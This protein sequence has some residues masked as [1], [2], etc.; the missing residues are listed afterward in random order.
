MSRILNA[1]SSWTKTRIMLRKSPSRRTEV[2][3]RKGTRN[4]RIESLESRQLFAIAPIAHLGDL[5]TLLIPTGTTPV[6]FFADYRESPHND[7]LGYFFVDGP[8]GRITKHQDSD[9]FGT[10]LLS[11]NGKPQYVR[12][13]EPGYSNEALAF[14]NSDVVFSSGEIGNLSN[15]H[16]VLDVYGDFYIAFYLIQG[17]STQAWRDA[18]TNGKPNVWF[19]I[20]DANADGYEHFQSTLR[21]DSFYRRGL[22]QYKVEDSNLALAKRKVAGNDSDLNDFVF[23]VNIVPYAYSD[24]YS[25]FNAG[26]DFNGTPQP[27]KLNQTSGLLWNDYLPSNPYRKPIVTHVSLDGETWNP[28]TDFCRNNIVIHDAS[29]HGT[30]TVFANGSI[31]FQPN[32]TDVWWKTAPVDSEAEPDPIEFQY[33]ISD[34][35]D[36]AEAYVSITHGFYQKGGPVD[37]RHQGKKM[38]L[39]AGGGDSTPFQ[40][41]RK[42]FF[43]EGGNGQDIVLISQGIEQREL[44]N[45][46]FDYYADGKSRSVTSLNITTREQANDPRMSKIVNGADAIWFGGGAQSFYQS[47]WE[48]TALFGAL[49]VAAANNVAIGGTSAGMAI[50]GQAAYVELPWDSV[51]SR[52]ATQ[53]P[54]DPRINIEYQ[55]GQLPFAAL[56]SGS[57]APLNNFITDT[58]FSSR[59][60]M[61]RLVAF[62][63]K[64]NMRGLGVDEETA[65]LIERVGNNWKWSTYGTGSVYIVTPSSTSVRPKYQDNLRLT[66]GPMN[67]YR[68]G[69]GTRNLTDVLSSG[70]S[71]RI[72]VTTGTVYTTENGGS[73]Y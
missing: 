29:L 14:N 71:Y 16:K 59:D 24:D 64:S 49:A 4:C 22:L 63:A 28:V 57:N 52:F 8:D 61:G 58:H 68:L 6:H 60:R 43:Q 44:V 1:F 21:N 41:G 37:N 65:V 48:G 39:L 11:A 13:G 31:D 5:S 20:G 27:L 53:A 70:P 73:L 66:Y 18:P 54:L 51:K 2:K 35:I 62:A 12:P 23:S 10:P 42:R 36:T 30:L 38:Y 72:W 40:E 69:P 15:G 46:V 26:A 19:S 67:V 3:R 32:S 56:S 17:K 45:F 25:V 50:L 7:E 34:G 47:V 9:P 33:R 55:G